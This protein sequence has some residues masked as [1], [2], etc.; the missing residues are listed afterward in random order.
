MGTTFLAEVQAVK[1]GLQHC[2]DLGVHDV[3]CF[4]D[5]T[6]VVEAL[7]PKVAVDQCWDR[8]VLSSVKDL[9]KRDW[10]AK[11]ALVARERN[12]AADTLACTATNV[13][14]PPR[15]WGQPPSSLVQA[16]L[17]DGVG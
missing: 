17:V 16:L 3:V 15:R 14:G 2:W 12:T 5:C 10:T 13:D 9:L 11:V 6:G 7:Q 8:D 1:L 4:T